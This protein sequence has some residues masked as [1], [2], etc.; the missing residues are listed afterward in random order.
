M[1]NNTEIIPCGRRITIVGTGNV[2]SHIAKALTRQKYDVSLIGSR[3]LTGLPEKSDVIIIAVKDDA[4]AETAKKLKGKAECMAHT[5]GSVPMAVLEGCA[6]AVGVFYPMQTFSKDVELNYPD[7]PFFIEGNS[8]EA[9]TV[10]SGIARSI[11]DNVR[12]ANSAD[13]K[14]LHLAAVFACNFTNHLMAI[15]DDI[16][17][18]NGMDYT[19]MLP[20]LRQTIDKLYSIPPSQAQTGPA[21]RLDRNVLDAHIDMLKGER[22]LKELYEEMTAQIILKTHNNRIFTLSDNPLQK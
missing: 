10:L 7:I 13:R 11:S 14:K 2:G 1:D 8:K 22:H 9:E 12:L 18:E 3:M 20:L 19:V 17:K 4:I 15:A 16:L 5:S 6:D 21:A